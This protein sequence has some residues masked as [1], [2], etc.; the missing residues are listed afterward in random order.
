MGSGFDGSGL[1]TLT[2]TAAEPE[3]FLPKLGAVKVDGEPEEW[4]GAAA[5]PVRLASCIAQRRPSHTWNGPADCGM[6]LFCGWNDERLCLAGFVA[7]DDIRAEQDGVELYV[8][9]R[10]G[11]A[12]LKSPYSEGSCQILV[13]PPVGDEAPEMVFGRADGAIAGAQLAGKRVAG[14]WTFELVL[15]WSGFPGFSARSGACVGLQ[16]AVADYDARDGDAR[17]PLMMTWQAVTSLFT[18]PQ[19]MMKWTLIE[20]VSKGARTDGGK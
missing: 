4:T 6:E 12:F 19:N 9:A 1:T 8:D 14:G 3:V 2:L 10:G 17:Q 11:A 16:F 20:M 13:R 7:D 5:V 18:S 15:P